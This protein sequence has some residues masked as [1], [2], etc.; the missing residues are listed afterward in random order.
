[1][2]GTEDAFARGGITTRKIDSILKA[3]I[4]A[5][6][7]TVTVLKSFILHVNVDAGR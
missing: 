6:K 3:E 1:M 7:G 5:L 2:S 4:D